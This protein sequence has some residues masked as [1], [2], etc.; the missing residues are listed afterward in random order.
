MKKNNRGFKRFALVAFVLLMGLTLLRMV[1]KEMVGM[2]ASEILVGDF[3]IIIIKSIASVIGLLIIAII[4]IYLILVSITI[5]SIIILFICD[6]ISD[7]IGVSLFTA[8]FIILISISSVLMFFIPITS[9]CIILIS[10]I[11]EIILIRKG[12][13]IKW[14]LYTCQL[15]IVDDVYGEYGKLVKE[16]LFK[17]RK[18]LS[19]KNIYFL[20]GVSNIR[21]I[22]IDELKKVNSKGMSCSTDL[23][24]ESLKMADK[25]NQARVVVFS[26]QNS[27]DY[28]ETVKNCKNIKNITLIKP[29]IFKSFSRFCKKA[30]TVEYYI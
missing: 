16:L 27:E 11:L 12:M 29:H 5:P 8:L 1:S 15:I 3:F 9:I 23:L 26:I 4:C 7:N 17:E 10:T 13:H 28:I 24:R 20:D 25:R 30:K 19:N 6:I 21:T 14:A 18:Y 22:K 2:D